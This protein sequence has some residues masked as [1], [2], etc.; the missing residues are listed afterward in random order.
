MRREIG[1]LDILLSGDT[2]LLKRATKEGT[3]D[4]QR[5]GMVA[6]HAASSAAKFSAAAAAAATAVFA[7]TKRSADTIDQLGKLPKPDVARILRNL[8]ASVE[9]GDFDGW[10]AAPRE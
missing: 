4:L 6:G 1:V 3:T 9:R 2:T 7:F 10:A 5:F 8:A